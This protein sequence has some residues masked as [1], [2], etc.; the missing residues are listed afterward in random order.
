MYSTCIDW[1]IENFPVF[2]G[3]KDAMKLKWVPRELLVCKFMER[4]YEKKK[5][6]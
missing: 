3:D 6:L 1:Q 4:K 2:W 5:K